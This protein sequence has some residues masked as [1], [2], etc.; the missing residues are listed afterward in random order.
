MADVSS[1]ETHLLHQVGVIVAGVDRVVATHVL[2][3]GR[4]ASL[5]VIV[6]D[7]L[8]DLEAGVLEVSL[9]AQALGNDGD[10][11]VVFGCVIF[12]LNGANVDLLLVDHDHHLPLVLI[13]GNSPEAGASEVVTTDVVVDSLWLGVDNNLV[14]ILFVFEGL[15]QFDLDLAILTKALGLLNLIA[16]SD[17]HWCVTIIIFVIHGL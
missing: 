13:L 12:V 16:Q 10:V 2:A 17:L 14:E 5:D 9:S 1:V 6:G 7:D 15:E 4:V 11:I 8:L 3:T